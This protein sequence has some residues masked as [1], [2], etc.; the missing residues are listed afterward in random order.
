V[1]LALVAAKVSMTGVFMDVLPINVKESAPT[2]STSTRMVPC[3]LSAKMAE[4]IA[5]SNSNSRH[6]A[7]PVSLANSL[8]LTENSE[9]KS[10]HIQI[11]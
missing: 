4:T 8:E 11:K 5:Y 10:N 6:I 1:K 3:G 7:G 2:S 9:R